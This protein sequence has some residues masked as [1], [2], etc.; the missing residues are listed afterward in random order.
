MRTPDTNPPTPPAAPPQQVPPAA[1]QRP[2]A[3][4]WKAAFTSRSFLT[5]AVVLGLAAVGLNAATEA[6]QVYFKKLPVPLRVRLDDDKSGLPKQLGN[7]VMVSEQNALDPD[8][9]HSLGTKDFAFRAYVDTAAIPAD[10]LAALK[11]T[12]NNDDQAAA[13]QAVVTRIQEVAPHAV[14]LLNVTYYTGMVDTVTHIPERCMVADGYEPKNPQ[15]VTLAAGS[16]D[17]GS[18]RQIATQFSTFED[19]TGRGRTNRHVAYFFHCNGGYEPNPVAVRV[20]LQNLFERHGYYAKVEL[21]ADDPA[22]AAPGAAAPSDAKRADE[23]AK[24]QAAMA[25]LLAQALPT[26]ERCLPDWKSVK[27]GG[28]AV[29]DAAR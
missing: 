23:A 25:D 20:K 29:A 27:A 8:V 10:V 16:Y 6:L 2:A 28:A 12:L 18:P 19:Q 26:I 14:L 3:S 1:P 22:R 9:Q 17:D 7:W 15:T 13:R 21:M 24:V 11:P 4:P 5:A